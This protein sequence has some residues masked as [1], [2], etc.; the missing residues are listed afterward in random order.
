[1]TA[2]FE[3]I[4]RTLKS[5]PPGRRAPWALLS[6]S[7]DPEHDSPAVLRDYAAMQAPTAGSFERWTFATGTPDEVRAVARFFGLTYETQSGQIVHS[8]RTV[9]V[10]PDGKVAAIFRGN[11]WTVDDAVTA[12]SSTDEHR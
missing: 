9:L 5:R 11:A 8:L 1:M 7:I 4:A 10:G 6:I 3:E 12:I 2:N